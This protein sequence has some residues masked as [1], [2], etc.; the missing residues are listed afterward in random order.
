L[1][2]TGNQRG[3]IEAMNPTHMIRVLLV[4]DHNVVRS[5][6]ATFLRAYDDLELVGEAKNGLEA[7]RLCREKSP[8]VILMDLMM[9]EMDGIAATRAIL[10]ES[11]QV[12]IIAM[13]SFEEE[14]LVQGVLAAGAISY[15][16]KNVTS[17]ELARAIRD[18]A[19]GRSTLSPEA[20][21]VL[22]QATRPVKQPLF[23][24]T[25]RE[26]E[27]LSLVVEGQS[28]QQIADNLVISITTVKAHMSNILSKLQ[29]SSRTEAI[30][31]A[32]KHKLVSL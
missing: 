12:K 20:A 30:A 32:I 6:L 7:V 17:D 14:Q 2:W 31:Y 29:V 1:N 3:G 24:L 5:G 21:R 27:V 13:T 22:I 16:I 15:L 25:E 26:R 28:N 11:P 18:A 19:S 10:A 8:D 23:D 9:P 4:D